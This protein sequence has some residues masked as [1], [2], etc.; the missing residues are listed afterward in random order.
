MADSRGMGIEHSLEEILDEAVKNGRKMTALG[1]TATYIPELGR[2]NKDYLGVCICTED[3]RYHV[4]GDT[5][6]RFT[7]QSISKVISL[8]AALEQ[9]GFEKTFDRV[10]M[11]PSGD[12]FDSLVRLDLASD[13]P[14]NPMINSGAIAI[15][16]HLSCE[17]SFEWMLALTRRLCMDEEITLDEKVYHSEMGHISRNKAI[18]YLLESKGILENNVEESLDLYVRMCSLGVTARSLA[19]F[20]LILASD[21]IN[22]LTGERL[23]HSKVVQTV[24]AIM[25]TCGM[26]DGSGRFAVEVGVPSKSGVGGGILSVVDKRMGI[27]IFGPALDAKG[28]SIAGQHVLRELSSRMRLHMFAD[29]VPEY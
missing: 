21:G 22:P 27:G 7:I 10:G 16:S 1:K 20:G 19:G 12:S 23:L 15:T 18:A 9:C 8:A 26:Y 25:L 14:S 24:K 28:N 4:S 29:N 2:V 17:V 11:E 6:I 13:H 5:D 3:G